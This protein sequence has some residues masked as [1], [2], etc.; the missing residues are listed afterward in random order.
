MTTLDQFFIA[1]ATEYEFKTAVETGK[2]RSGLKMVGAFANGVGG[3]IC[4]GDF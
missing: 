3:S 4:F 2:P 1:E